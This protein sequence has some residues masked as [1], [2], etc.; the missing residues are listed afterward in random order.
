MMLHDDVEKIMKSCRNGMGKSFMFAA[1]GL[2]ALPRKTR[3]LGPT[4]IMEPHWKNRCASCTGSIVKKSLRT[5]ASVRIISFCP[6][7]SDFSRALF[8]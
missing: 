7:L 8:E 4:S 5:M 2:T 6:S 1:A 3:R